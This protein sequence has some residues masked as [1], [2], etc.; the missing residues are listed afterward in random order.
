MFILLGTLED[1][2]LAAV[3]RALAERSRESLVIGDPFMDPAGTA[4]RFDGGG[5]DTVLAIGGSTIPVEGVLAARRA[6]RPF[7]KSAQWTQQ[8][9][10]Y[11]HAEADAALLGWLWGLPCP[12]IDRLPAW[13][14][15]GIRRPIV[16]W[17]PLL[18]QHGLPPLAS[19]VTGY[20][21]EL[22]RFMQGQAGAALEPIAGAGV[23]HLVQPSGVHQ[24]AET[25]PMAPVRLSELHEGGWR[26]CVAGA[27][28]VW[29]DGTP[30][31]ARRLSSRL[32][33]FAAAAGL[34]FV[35]FVI[36]SGEAPRM[37]D[38]E[39]RPRFELFGS[40]AQAAIADG[41]AEALVSGSGVPSRTKATSRA[42]P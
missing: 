14:W 5:S 41:V 12:V 37:V 21:D 32:A 28:V 39:H 25:A 31:E 35:E 8:D 20:A 33:A 36:A 11:T 3:G 1:P 23:R 22:S 2:C 16:A 15:Y 9:L 38:V 30:D 29:D 26:A 17:G 40:A 10:L 6:A 7:E 34:A 42:L 4:W 27:H 13:L 24:V 18:Q 19:V